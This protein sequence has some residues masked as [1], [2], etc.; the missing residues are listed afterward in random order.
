MVAECKRGEQETFGWWEIEKGRADIAGRGQRGSGGSTPRTVQNACSVRAATLPPCRPQKGP[1]PSPPTQLP[2][3]SLS[4]Y[5]SRPAQHQRPPPLSA[6]VHDGSS[7]TIAWPPC[8]AGPCA[9]DGLRL[10]W[11]RPGLQSHLHARSLDSRRTQRRLRRPGLAAP[12]APPVP[13][14]LQLP[15]AHIMAAPCTAPASDCVLLSPSLPADHHRQLGGG[16]L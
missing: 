7:K 6:P 12:S 15:A 2:L 1:P 11:Q 13:W 8:R 16:R 3:L 5:E 4:I 9:P 10:D 14:P